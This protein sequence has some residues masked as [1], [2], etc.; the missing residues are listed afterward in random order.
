[1]TVEAL[2]DKAK[3]MAREHPIKFV[4]TASFLALGAVPLAAFVAYAVVTLVASIIGAVV[5]EVVLLGLGIA[6]LAFVLV[7]VG[8]LTACIVSSFAT[9][10]YAYRVASCTLQRAGQTMHDKTK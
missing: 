8:C 2:S 5:F 9:L 7:L 10:Y 6:A 3:L 1:M 4:A